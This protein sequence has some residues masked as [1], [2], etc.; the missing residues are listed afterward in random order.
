MQ[1]FRGQRIGVLLGGESAEREISL[2][3]GEAVLGALLGRGWDAV[4]IHVDRDLDRVLRQEHVA[5][6]FIALHGRGADGAVQG[7][8]ETLGI[9]YTGSSVSATALAA[10]KLKAKEL[11][12]LHNLPTPAYYCHSRGLGSAPEQHHG[13][14]FPCVVK[15]RSGGSGIGVSLARDEA[16]L[17]AA[18]ETALLLD[19]DVLVER[20]AGEREVQV[21][22]LDGQVLG[23]AEVITGGG[24][25]W[26]RERDPSSDAGAGPFEHATRS[27]PGQ[28]EVHA[29]PRIAAD[30]LRGV[31][32]LAMRA[33][34][35]LGC[36]GAA[37]VD[38]LL[39]ERGNESILEVDALPQL[40]P[41]SLL[42]HLA[43]ARH[44]AFPDLVERILE[45][46]RLHAGR[47]T[48]ARSAVAWSEPERRVAPAAEPH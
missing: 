24:G 47:R 17:E 12:R 35:L 45:G 38:V 18:V 1:T 22:F 33:H 28:L 20:F 43:E 16:E 36:T 26:R 9:P 7:L 48:R 2:R 4:P 37:R 40:A 5:V 41:G 39:S 14:G 27:A 10:D 29:P 25:S 30:R 13:F 11:L 32:T 15:P 23:A 19:D 42:A 31:V 46:A 8:L 3:S 21:A 44:V 6:A 34:H